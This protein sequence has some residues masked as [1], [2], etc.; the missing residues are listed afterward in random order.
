VVIGAQT[1]VCKSAVSAQQPHDVNSAENY[2]STSGKPADHVSNKSILE[3]LQTNITNL[4][5]CFQIAVFS[6]QQVISAA[7][8]QPIEI[9]QQTQCGLS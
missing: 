4:T 1:A 2:A 5:T 8:S 9:L 6:H 3:S 7:G